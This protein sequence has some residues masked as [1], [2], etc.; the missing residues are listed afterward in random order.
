MIDDQFLYIFQ[1]DLCLKWFKSKFLLKQHAKGDKCEVNKLLID[2]KN[3]EISQENNKILECDPEIKNIARKYELY[4]NSEEVNEHLEYEQNENNEI[5]KGNDKTESKIILQYEIKNEKCNNNILSNCDE[6][7]INE[8]LQTCEICSENFTDNNS[9]KIHMKVH[10]CVCFICSK[11][12]DSSESVDEHMKA[13]SDKP[14]ICK[15]C[16][17]SFTAHRFLQKHM[18]S[19]KVVSN[20]NIMIIIMY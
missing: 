16:N 7:V 15:I 6:T 1:C 11:K 18:G 3:D 10:E 19:H 2:G 9:L 13:H 14:Y 17:L 8:E 5:L 12:F 20:F 4:D